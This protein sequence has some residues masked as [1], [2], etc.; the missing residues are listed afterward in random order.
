MGN[1]KRM[2]TLGQKNKRKNV[3]SHVTGIAESDQ[4]TAVI[5]REK[6]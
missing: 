3:T 1:G 4:Q 2:K 6:I 5:E